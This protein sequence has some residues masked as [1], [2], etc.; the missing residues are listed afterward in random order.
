MS[1]D[2]EAD[3][4]SEEEPEVREVVITPAVGAGLAWLD[5]VNL[6]EVFQHRASVMKSVPKF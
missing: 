5:Q 2:R 3:A 1:E 6:V 4:P